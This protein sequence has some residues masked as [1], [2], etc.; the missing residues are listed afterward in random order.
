MT[1]LRILMLE[2]MA[3]D[4]E[5]VQRELAKGQLNFT[6]KLVATRGAFIRELT[7]FA[8]DLILADYS[9]PGFDGI[10]ALSIT[11]AQRPDIPF[12]F[13]SGAI[14]EELAIDTLKNGATDYVLKQRMS[15][16]LPSVH[17]A[18]SEAAERVS[19]VQ[20]EEALR[21]LLLF[22]DGD[23]WRVEATGQWMMAAYL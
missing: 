17:R 1:K 15:R 8:P 2:D 5:L 10:E 14:G 23:T 22:P 7:D 11:R 16:L 6:T 19:R 9:L 20:A 3:T 21:H 12:V 4:A 18:L 13:V